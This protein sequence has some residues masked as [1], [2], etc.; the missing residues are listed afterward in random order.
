VCS[1]DLFSENIIQKALDFINSQLL[2]FQPNVFPTGRQSVQLEYEKSNGNY[3]E[4][5]IFDDKCSAYS[6]IVDKET[7]YESLSFNEIIKLINEFYSRI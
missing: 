2:R 3:L 1:S 5:E 4:I 6:E 7:E